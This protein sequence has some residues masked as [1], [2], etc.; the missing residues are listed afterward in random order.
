MH[1]TP[2]LAGS[3]AFAVHLSLYQPRDSS[4]CS[5]TVGSWREDHCTLRKLMLS[6]L[7]ASFSKLFL[8]SGGGGYRISN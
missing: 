2:S 3:R 8:Y 5:L 6:L 7:C 1:Y 4:L